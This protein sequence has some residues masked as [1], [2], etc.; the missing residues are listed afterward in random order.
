[1]ALVLLPNADVHTS[2]LGLLN[3]FNQYTGSYTQLSAGIVF[4]VIPLLVVY[5]F[6]QRYLI[7]GLLGVAIK[8]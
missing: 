1:M 5:M 2:P 3:F 8:A 4:G 6:L 7:S